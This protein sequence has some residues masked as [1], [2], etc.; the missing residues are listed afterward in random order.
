MRKS[1]RFLIGGILIAAAI[2]FLV[3]MGLR[4]AATYYYKINE[5]LAQGSSLAGKTIRVEGEVAPDV[6]REVGSLHFSLFD[7]AVQNATLQVVYQGP[8]PDTFQ[9]GRNIVAEGKYDPGGVFEAT[10][11]I[12]KCP[13]KY[14]SEKTPEN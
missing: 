1:R 8:V 12:T 9:V 14:Q 10:S 5:V 4:S 11:I 7:P 3:F 13:S 2:A 6:V